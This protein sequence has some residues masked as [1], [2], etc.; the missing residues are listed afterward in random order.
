MPDREYPSKVRVL[1]IIRTIRTRWRIRMALKGLCIVFGAAFAAFLLSAWGLEAARFSP[2]AV[3]ALRILAWAVVAVV[4]Y[5]FLVRPLFKRVSDQ[6]VALYLEEHE[7]SLEAAIMGAV[8]VET[9][10]GPSTQTASRGLLDALVERAVT[11]AR[12]V[13]YGHG[14]DRRGLYQSSGA[15][16]FLVVAALLFLFF[17]PADLRYGMTAI[18]LPT[19]EAAEVSP[20][21][22]AVLPGDVSVAR[23]ADQLIMAEL[24]GFNSDQV[25]VFSRLDGEESF[26]RL[27]MLPADSGRFDLLLLNLVDNTEYF[28]EAN[29]IRSASYTI[30]VADLPYVEAMKHTYYFPS[31]TGLSPREVEFGGSIAAL[32]GTRVELLIQSTIPTSGGRLLVND[33]VVMEL[34]PGEDGALSGEILVRAEGVYRIDLAREDGRMVTASPEYTIDLLT[35][36]PPSV[37]ISKPGRDQSASALEEIFIEAKADDDYGIED[38]RLVYS[39]N[40]EPEDTV[41]LY[42]SAGSP[43]AEVSA[44]YTLFLEEYELD[45]GDVV[46]YYAVATD[47][48]SGTPEE[49]LS[50]IYFIDVRPFRRDFR[51]AEQQPPPQEVRSNPRARA[52]VANSRGRA[53]FRISKEMWWLRP[54]T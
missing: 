28:A 22:I 34:Q 13:D 54:S 16:A 9:N 42:G 19:T 10:R 36:L 51:Q 38:L 49:A 12:A 50:D 2:D 30:E 41:S 27:S 4:T 29:G 6:Q 21:S 1:P 48:R 11:K 17:G 23:G 31:Y 14:I 26:Q 15:F 25:F 43:L 44:G 18:M 45:P 3:F 47:N 37:A 53:A 8:E 7:P 39:V 46:S 32:A 5:F 52:R 33:S 24:K 20:Y 40:G 35:D